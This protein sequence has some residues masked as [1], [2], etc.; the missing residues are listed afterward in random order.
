MPVPFINDSGL[1]DYS[2]DENAE[3]V[4]LQPDKNILLK[5]SQSS[6]RGGVGVSSYIK[7]YGDVSLE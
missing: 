3:E 5:F 2:A 6:T 4:N 1:K 7:H